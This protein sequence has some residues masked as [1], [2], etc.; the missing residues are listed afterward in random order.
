MSPKLPPPAVKKRHKHAPP[1]LSSARPTPPGRDDL[2]ISTVALPPHLA[3]AA[4]E[5]GRRRFD[6]RFDS[7]CSTGDA[8]TATRSYAFLRDMRAAE[9]AALD[10]AARRGDDAAALRLKSMRSV[11]EAAKERAREE[12]VRRTL[13][14]EERE[15][16][17]SGGKRAWYVKEKAVKEKVVERKFEELK[18]SG[19][20][21][22]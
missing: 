16:V 19:R 15:R 7:A 1:E 5:A 13:R 18:A 3:A 10:R 4:R 6:P 11:D 14:R 9:E 20:L 22:K 17:A 8:A 12:D 2:P 21:Q